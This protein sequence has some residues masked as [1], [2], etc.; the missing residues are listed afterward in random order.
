M[1]QVANHLPFGLFIKD[2][3]HFK[4]KNIKLIKA[5]LIVCLVF[6]VN[7]IMAQE[8]SDQNIPQ[9][10]EAAFSAKYP[11]AKLKNWK[12]KDNN[13][14]ARYVFSGHKYYATFDEQGNW[15]QTESKIGWPWHLP[16]TV[17]A[18]LK[19]S[20]HG[21]WNTYSVKDVEKPTGKYYQILVDNANHPADAFHENGSNMYW[22][23][24]VKADGE[25][26][27]EKNVT[28]SSKF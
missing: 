13:Y 9:N 3:I 27:D 5:L 6:Y 24:E 12:K 21:S 23:V 11:S 19:K 10:V 22:V 14:T 25:L 18:A 2:Q 20:K 17:K 28:Y 1:V 26:I 16:V 4:M 7:H 8:K 15:E